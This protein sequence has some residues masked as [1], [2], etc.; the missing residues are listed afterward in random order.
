[1]DINALCSSWVP[2]D[3]RS[4]RQKAIYTDL[5]PCGQGNC[6]QYVSKFNYYYNA[7]SVFWF[8]SNKLCTWETSLT[9]LTTTP[10]TNIILQISTQTCTP[11][12]THPYTAKTKVY[13]AKL[14]VTVCEYSLIFSIYFL[15]YWKTGCDL[16]YWYHDPLIGCGWQFEKHWPRGS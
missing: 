10:V 7:Q 6:T 11:P 1:M 16:W 2:R 9:F 8:I 13:Q 12:H 15:F 14:I 4:T 3:S 5:D